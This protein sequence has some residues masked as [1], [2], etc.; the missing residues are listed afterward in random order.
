M[1]E[2]TTEVLN[3]KTEKL[4]VYFALPKNLRRN[5]KHLISINRRTDKDVIHIHI[6]TLT[7]RDLTQP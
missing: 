2:A 5:C 6:H 7:H 1:N 3:K 4:L